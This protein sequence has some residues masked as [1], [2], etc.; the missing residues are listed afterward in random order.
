MD[1]YDYDNYEKE[2]ER[3]HNYIVRCDSLENSDY[4]YDC[5]RQN[6]GHEYE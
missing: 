6:K 1:Y 3:Q 5:Y 4:E 2:Q